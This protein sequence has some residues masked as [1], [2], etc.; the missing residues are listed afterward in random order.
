MLSGYLIRLQGDLGSDMTDGYAAGAFL[1]TG[2]ETLEF[3]KQ[4]EPDS[5]P[6]IETCAENNCEK[7]N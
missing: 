6:V 5:H 2:R 7:S 1:S 4:S 3:R